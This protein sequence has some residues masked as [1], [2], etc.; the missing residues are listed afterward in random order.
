MFNAKDGLLF[1]LEFLANT[2][3]SLGAAALTTEIYLGLRDVA[4]IVVSPLPAVEYQLQ[5]RHRLVVRHR[6]D[7]L[8]NATAISVT[9]TYV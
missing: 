8:G 3:A 2:D 4:T 6:P 7:R 5:G 9:V 1:E